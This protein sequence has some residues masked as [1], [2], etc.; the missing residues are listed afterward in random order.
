M[1]V[2]AFFVSSQPANASECTQILGVSI[3]CG[4][5]YHYSPDGGL[6]SAIGIRCNYG[7][8]SSTHWLAEGTGSKKYCA[9]TDQ[10]YVGSGE[11]I[12]CKMSNNAAW[13]DLNWKLMFD[14]TGW[15]KI[16]DTFNDGYGCT[17]R[18]D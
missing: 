5:I 8:P 3:V 7:D 14:A 11:E 6:D 4:T 13:G 9:D 1:M 18:A 16:D 17:K 2:A 10:V 12:W 15:H